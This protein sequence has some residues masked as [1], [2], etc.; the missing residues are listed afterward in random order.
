MNVKSKGVDGMG[1]KVSDRTKEV[2]FFGARLEKVIES[3]GKAVRDIAEASGLSVPYLTNIIKGRRAPTFTTL[4]K[5]SEGLDLPF[6]D[7][8]FL[9]V[10]GGGFKTSESGQEKLSI[11]KMNDGRGH[12]AGALKLISKD[13]FIELYP[14][15]NQDESEQYIK[16]YIRDVLYR[17]ALSKSKDPFG[18]DDTERLRQEVV[19]S[20]ISL[21]NNGLVFIKEQLGIYRKF[22]KPI[23]RTG[24]KE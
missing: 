20:I 15:Y 19:N 9:L 10:V 23:G 2:Q 21:D 24:M 12:S 13:D 6:E 11:W 4:Q 16:A 17:E 22:V 3:K 5:L 18:D 8:A 14:L 7:I 1:E